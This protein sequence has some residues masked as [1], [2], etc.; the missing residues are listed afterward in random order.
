MSY[1]KHSESVP[2]GAP[3]DKLRS[4]NRLSITKERSSKRLLSTDS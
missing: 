4:L 2:G 1:R 3:E